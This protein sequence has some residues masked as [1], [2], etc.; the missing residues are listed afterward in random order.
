[1][2]HRT[3]VNRPNSPYRPIEAFFSGNTGYFHGAVGGRNLAEMGGFRPTRDGWDGRDDTR[4]PG[5]RPV[6]FPVGRSILWTYPASGPSKSIYGGLAG[7]ENMQSRLAGGC[8]C[9][10][11]KQWC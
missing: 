8:G 1:M 10:Q 11:V 3:P 7:R 9:Q 6:A 5:S 2:N 4:P